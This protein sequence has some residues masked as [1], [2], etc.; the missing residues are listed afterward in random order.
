[1]MNS[2]SDIT[3]WKEVQAGSLTAFEI[4]F[5]RYYPPLCVYALQ[6]LPDSDLAKDTV[7]ELFVTLWENRNE[8]TFTSSF[9]SYLYASIRFN[10][11]RRYNKKEAADI[12]LEKLR[13]LPSKADDQLEF[14]E[15]YLAIMETIQ[16]LPERCR[17]TFVLSRFE[18]LSYTQI[19]EKMNISVKTVE[20]H[21]SKALRLIHKSL[22]HKLHNP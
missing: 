6:F 9:K 3:L 18:Q 2:D 5:K 10:S 20:A 8:L 15:L 12:P 16:A 7:Q 1:M 22:D 14:E 17:R 13:E 11:I 19:A 4:L 21:I